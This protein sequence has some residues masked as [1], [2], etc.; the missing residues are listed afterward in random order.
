[1]TVQS[2]PLGKAPKIGFLS[3]RGIERAFVV[4]LYLIMLALVVLSIVGTF[5]GLNQLPAPL[6]SP[7]QLAMD[8]QAAPGRLGLAF[9]IQIVLM[10][11]QYGA[12]QMAQYDWRWWGLYLVSL[13]VSVYYNVQAYWLPLLLLASW[14]VAALLIICGDVLPEFLAVRRTAPA[15]KEP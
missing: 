9:A 12:R 2:K 14:P 15:K 7:L 8:V 1:V 6:T 3:P 11:V 10:V 4:V 5:Y 13:G